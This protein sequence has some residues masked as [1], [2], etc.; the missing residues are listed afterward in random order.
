MSAKIAHLSTFSAETEAEI[1]S[2]SSFVLFAFP[3]LCLVYVMSVFNLSSVL[4]Y[5]EHPT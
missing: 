1:R 3:G 2:T 5:P 4:Y